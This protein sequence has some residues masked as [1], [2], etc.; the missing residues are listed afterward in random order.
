[1]GL[2]QYKLDICELY[3]N[4]IV[5][6]YLLSAAI[7]LIECHVDKLFYKFNFTRSSGQ[8]TGLKI[9]IC[10]AFCS[11]AFVRNLV[12]GISY[13]ILDKY[14]VFMLYGCNSRRWQNVAN[15]VILNLQKSQAASRNWE[16]E[17]CCS[18]RYWKVGEKY[19]DK[20]LYLRIADFCPSCYKYL[21]DFAEFFNTRA[22]KIRFMGLIWFVCVKIQP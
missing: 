14:N 21:T 11:I 12:S 1:M 13:V 20:L 2:S 22:F 7:L 10:G 19:E 8:K 3:S 15:I 6:I 16:Q 17:L 5:A 4:N 9:T 18:V